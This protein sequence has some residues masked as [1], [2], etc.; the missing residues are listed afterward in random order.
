MIEI[1]HR[2]LDSFKKKI[3]KRPSNIYICQ[4][5]FLEWLIYWMIDSWDR[6]VY[7]IIIIMTQ[8]ESPM[9]SENESKVT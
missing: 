8:H 7:L 3:T 9:S 6:D 5:Y 2:L 4:G 1:F